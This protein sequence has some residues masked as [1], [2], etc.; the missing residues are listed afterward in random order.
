LKNPLVIK[1]IDRQIF[2]KYYELL[3]LDCDLNEHDNIEDL[4]SKV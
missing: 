3:N 4:K 1:E 2:L